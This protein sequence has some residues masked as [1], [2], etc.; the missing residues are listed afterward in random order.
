[1]T[2]II[3]IN[4]QKS[5]VEIKNYLFELKISLSDQSRLLV[6]VEFEREKFSPGPG[7]EP[8]SLA[9]RANALTNWAI[10]DKYQSKIE[11]IS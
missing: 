11:L 4:W 2:Q 5:T 1:M 9:F 8:G 7:L 10:Q 6:D 3:L